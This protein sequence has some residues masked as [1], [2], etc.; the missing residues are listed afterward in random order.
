MFFRL[1]LV[2][3]PELREITRADNNGEIELDARGLKSIWKKKIK[4]W[5]EKAG[6]TACDVADGDRVG[7][8]KDMPGWV[9]KAIKSW[10]RSEAAKACVAWKA[11]NAVG[12]ATSG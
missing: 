5:L 10:V 2:E 11:A 1:L 12:N 8:L 6:S 7:K 9:W 3:H 4:N